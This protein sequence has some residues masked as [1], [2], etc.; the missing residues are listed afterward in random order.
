M[1]KL[2][3]YFKQFSIA[4]SKG[5]LAP[6]LLEI[7]SVPVTA[8]SRGS[9]YDSGNHPVTPLSSPESQPGSEA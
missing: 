9:T 1:G 6:M 4:Y 2:I 7:T 3:K 8:E 5:V